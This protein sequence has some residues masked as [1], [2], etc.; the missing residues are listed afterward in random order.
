M[1]ENVFNLSES[2]ANANA[3]YLAKFTTESELD[4]EIARLYNVIN[5]QIPDLTEDIDFYKNMRFSN[6]C[7]GKGEYDETFVELDLTIIDKYNL[8]E[9]YSNYYGPRTLLGRINHVYESLRKGYDEDNIELVVYAI[10]IH[11]KRLEKEYKKLLNDLNEEIGT[12]FDETNF[13]EVLVKE[14]IILL[15]EKLVKMI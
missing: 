13:D 3:K 10:Y 9:L 5:K 14:K 1:T 12:N 2:D 8:K 7:N 11:R 4:N 15:Y 6:S